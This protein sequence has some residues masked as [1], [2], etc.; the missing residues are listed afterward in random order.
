MWY[1]FP[2]TIRLCLTSGDCAGVQVTD[3]ITLAPGLT[4][5]R[6]GIGAAVFAQG[7][8]VDGIMG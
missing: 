1:R 7:F 6:Q 8:V 3:E 4:I 5:K 2:A